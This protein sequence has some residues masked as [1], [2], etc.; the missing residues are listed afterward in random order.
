VNDNSGY[1]KAIE[2]AIVSV[3]WDLASMKGWLETISRDIG[4][5]SFSLALL[6][7]AIDGL[8]TQVAHLAETR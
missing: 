5:I 6:V 3:A 8:T 7:K 1:G 4:T 2:E